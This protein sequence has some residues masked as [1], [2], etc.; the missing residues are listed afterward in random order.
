M[1]RVID[2]PSGAKIEVR[3]LTGRESKIL[4][5][6]DAIKGGVFLDKIL[7]ACTVSVLDHGPYAA[8][9][10]F[11]WAKALVG[12]RF[13]ALLQIRVLS[14]GEAY[15]FK[16]QCKEESCRK[17]WEIELNLVSELPVQRL[18]DDGRALFAA[19]N[20][21][22]TV[23]DNGKTVR[24]RLPIGQDEQIAAKAAGFDGAFIQAMR[25]RIISIDG[26]QDVRVYLEKCEWKAL[27][28]LLEAFDEHNCGVKT[29]IEV[30]CPTCGAI[31]ELQLP[32]GRG[33]F[34]PSMKSKKVKT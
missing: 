17:Q 12:D 23:D 16:L 15:A 31:Q 18:S 9:S 26:E 14:L 27:L 5:D 11:D 19:G 24:Y 25:Q 22:S 28:A 20:V 30:E 10:Q 29:D 7:N 3:S 6:R 21:F 32:F 8:T 33:F 2:L 4:S 13:Y 34:V 1:S